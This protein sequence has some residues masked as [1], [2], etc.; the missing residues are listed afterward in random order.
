M[1]YETGPLQAVINKAAALDEMSTYAK[2]SGK[3]EDYTDATLVPFREALKKARENVKKNDIELFNAS[4][5]EL[6]AAIKALVPH[7]APTDM[8]NKCKEL[9][10]LAKVLIPE[11]WPD[12]AWGMVDMK[13]KQV[14]HMTPCSPS[15]YGQGLSVPVSSRHIQ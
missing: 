3:T 5:A 14:C 13:M 8:I 4:I 2:K 10:E 6:E 12:A 9:M 11:Q 1:K 15:P 7:P